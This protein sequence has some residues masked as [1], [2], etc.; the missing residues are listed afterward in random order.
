MK[1]NKKLNNNKFKAILK[2][3]PECSILA[4]EQF[5]DFEDFF[6]KRTFPSHFLVAISVP[7]IFE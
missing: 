5:K 6:K 2:N 3:W 4:N 1:I 7:S